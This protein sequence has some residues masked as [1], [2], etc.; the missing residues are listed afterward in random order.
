MD[1]YVNETITFQERVAFGCLGWNTLA[2]RH[3][4]GDSSL[5]ALSMPSKLRLLLNQKKTCILL[6]L[7][8][9]NRYFLQAF[10]SFSCVS[11][12]C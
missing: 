8:Y 5:K 2:L 3:C 10:C 11:C 4:I 7:Y 9:S 12:Y 1:D 6:E